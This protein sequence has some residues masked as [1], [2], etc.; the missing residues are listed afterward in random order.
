VDIDL[1]RASTWS[2]QYFEEVMTFLKSSGMDDFARQ[3]QE[4]RDG[5]EEKLAEWDRIEAVAATMTSE[6]L[7]VSGKGVHLLKDE[8]PIQ[9]Q[10]PYSSSDS[11]QEDDDE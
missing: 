9:D 11:D 3:A 10:G 2:Q 6:E 4:W 7:A 1:T 8:S 5:G